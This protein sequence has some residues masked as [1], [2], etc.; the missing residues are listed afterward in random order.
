MQVN[1]NN[2]NDIQSGHLAP[3][4]LVILDASIVGAA[5]DN[6]FAGWSQQNGVL[7]LGCVAT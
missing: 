2:R 5:G 6:L 1:C 4:H 7:K 3:R